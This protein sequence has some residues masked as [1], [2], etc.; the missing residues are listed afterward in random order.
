[1][2]GVMVRHT[3]SLSLL[4]ILEALES[5]GERTNAQ[6]APEQCSAGSK[7][8]ED[9]RHNPVASPL[10]SQACLSS[11]SSPPTQKRSISVSC[12]SWLGNY[13]PVFPFVTLRSFPLNKHL[14]K[15]RSS[16]GDIF[17]VLPQPKFKSIVS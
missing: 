13:R 16:I 17:I 3:G 6:S 10:W 8:R 7:T 11:S 12:R 4:D 9:L 2:A 1:M 15:E 14:R 5:P